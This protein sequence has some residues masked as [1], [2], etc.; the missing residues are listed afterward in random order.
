MVMASRLWDLGIRALMAYSF[1]IFQFLDPETTCLNVLLSSSLIDLGCFLKGH[2]PAF[3]VLRLPYPD[4]NWSFK[5]KDLSDH[6]KKL[7]MLKVFSVLNHWGLVF[8]SSPVNSGSKTWKAKF[9]PNSMAVC[10]DV[11]GKSHPTLN[12]TDSIFTHSNGNYLL[13]WIM[14][15]VHAILFFL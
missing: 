10:I 6:V 15:M 7:K 12:T 9:L 4:Q 14:P 3:L 2:R 13:Q 1:D 5:L 11:I 8:R